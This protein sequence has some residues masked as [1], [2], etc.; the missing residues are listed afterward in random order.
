MIPPP[1]TLATLASPSLIEAWA[2]S[3]DECGG[4]TIEEFLEFL[5]DNARAGDNER[6]YTGRMSL[7]LEATGS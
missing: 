1:V 4:G 3:F 2:R 5:G 7:G 6:R